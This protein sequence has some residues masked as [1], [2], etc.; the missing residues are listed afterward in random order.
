M[1]LFAERRFPIW[2]YFTYCWKSEKKK[3]QMTPALMWVIERE[4]QWNKYTYLYMPF[5]KRFQ[6]FMSSIKDL[7]PMIKEAF[8]FLVFDKKAK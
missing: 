2:A 8:R 3:V 1:K 5:W 7:A 4:N 6:L